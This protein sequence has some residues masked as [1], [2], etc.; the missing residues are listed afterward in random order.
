MCGISLGKGSTH[1]SPPGALWPVSVPSGTVPGRLACWPAQPVLAQLLKI[2]VENLS[3][4][5]VLQEP[6][7][8][9]TPSQR[10]PSWLPHLAAGPC[11]SPLCWPLCQPSVPSSWE[12][13]SGCRAGGGTAGRTMGLQLSTMA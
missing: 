11:A 8:L 3:P 6:V 10:P 7:A 12:G 9:A 4:W 2:R 13:K 5:L 1:Q